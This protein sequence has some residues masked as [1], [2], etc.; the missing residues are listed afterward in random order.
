MG[1]FLSKDYQFRGV[2]S[3]LLN[4]LRESLPPYRAFSAAAKNIMGSGNDNDSALEPLFRT[5][6]EQRQ[7]QKDQRITSADSWPHACNNS[8]KVIEYMDRLIE[9]IK[10]DFANKEDHEGN[11]LFPETVLNAE[12][13]MMFDHCLQNLQM[14]KS[15]YVQ[16]AAGVPIVSAAGGRA[17]PGVGLFFRFF[18]FSTT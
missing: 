2:Y 10:N 16:L 1:L 9:S 14:I 3:I 11:L 15:D 18:D 12:K 17:V 8:Y 7:S 4:N 5:L 6:T 13:K